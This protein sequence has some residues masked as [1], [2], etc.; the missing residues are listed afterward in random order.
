MR[1]SATAGRS[2]ALPLAQR[3]VAQHPRRLEQVVE[4]GFFPGQDLDRR[5]HAG[6]D[7]KRLVVGAEM[8]FIGAD[9]DPIECF[10]LFTPLGPVVGERVGADALDLAL[11]RPEHR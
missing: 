7:R 4:H 5:D 8:I 6:Q 2:P 11:E 3:F 10:V 1:D 9:H